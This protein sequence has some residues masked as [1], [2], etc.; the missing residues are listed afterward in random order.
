MITM[1]KSTTPEYQLS[2]SVNIASFDEI[3]ENLSAALSLD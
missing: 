1:L 2:G 3:S